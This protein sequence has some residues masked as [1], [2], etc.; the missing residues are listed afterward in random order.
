MSIQ[1]GLVGLPNVGKSTLFN[2]LT[3]SQV[4]AENYPFC[5]IEPHTAITVVPDERM[6]KLQKLYDSKKLIP[7]HMNFVDIAGLVKGASSGEGLGNQ[8]L[9][10][11]RAVDLIIHVLRVFEDGNITNTRGQIEPLEDFAII[12]TELVL[13]DI[14]SVTK[15]IT[16]M[17]QLLKAARNKPSEL[18]AVQAE[19][20]Q[21]QKLF[22]ALD[23]G[24]VRIIRACY[25]EHPLPHLDLLIIKNFMIVA[26]VG[27]QELEGDAYRNNPYFQ[28]LV[29]HFGADMVVPVSAKIESELAQLEPAEQQ[30]MMQMLGITY[31]GLDKIIQ[32]AYKKLG[33]ITFFTCG[34]QEIHAWPIRQGITIRAAA[35]EIHSD[36]E[37]GFI[38][39]EVLNYDDLLQCGSIAKAR[40][41]GKLR[42]EGQQY[43]VADGDIINVKFAV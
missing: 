27:E 32:T 39:A 16:K 38:C 30:E 36:L 22:K 10:H 8:F 11:I 14:E 24:D 33:L 21:L 37:R 1:A 23:T 31:R 9:S 28:Q 15:R 3:N 18:T 29:N 4:P 35:G 2:A 20:E 41:S 25:E 5:T 12:N 19:Q 7:S 43:I 26:N 42:T 6:G 17:E 40:E 34:P 13:K